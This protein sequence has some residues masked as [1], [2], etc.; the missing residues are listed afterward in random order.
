MRSVAQH[1]TRVITNLLEVFRLAGA[2]SRVLRR[3]LPYEALNSKPQLR[4]SP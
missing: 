2:D 3:A 4:C 1:A